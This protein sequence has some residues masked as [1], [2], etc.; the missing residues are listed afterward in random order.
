MLNIAVHAWKTMLVNPKRVVLTI[1]GIVISSAFFVVASVFTNAIV[2]MQIDKYENF[3]PYVVYI[4]QP[5]YNEQ[6]QNIADKFGDAKVLP[7]YEDNS[8]VLHEPM[9]NDTRSVYGRLIGTIQDF[10]DY[11]VPSVDS[12]NSVQQV[13]LLYGRAFSEEDFLLNR[14]V[15]IISN[16][17][18]KM[19][20]GDENP[21]GKTVSLKNNAEYFIIGVLKDTDDIFRSISKFNKQVQDGE[22]SEL[23]I[24]IYVPETCLSQPARAQAESVAIVFPKVDISSARDLIISEIG[25]SSITTNVY[26][27]AEII[28]DI[29]RD[30][31]RIN[32]TIHMLMVIMLFMS[33]IS[34]F[35]ILMFSFK[36]RVKEIAIRKAIGAN[37]GHVLL[38]FSFESFYHGTIGGFIGILLGIIVVVAVAPFV[39][40]ASIS[41]ILLSISWTTLAIPLLSAI[42]VAQLFSFLPALSVVMR[43]NVIA[44]LQNEN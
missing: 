35:V 44:S 17:Y 40:Q 18:C 30:S 38:Q 43:R 14:R 21:L 36:D 7:Y 4:S 13:T 39:M 31:D 24:P 42:I 29:V 22:N 41:T 6:I 2:S 26:T 33:G 16:S 37:D 9:D 12:A 5:L 8:Y 23:V 10:N 3:N 11:V 32:Q 20:F 1:L 25:G 27:R 15:A 34:L 19:F 28:A